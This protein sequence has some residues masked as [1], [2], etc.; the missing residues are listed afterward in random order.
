MTPSFARALM[1]GTFMY[2]A[3]VTWYWMFF[4]SI[5]PLGIGSDGSGSARPTQ[6]ESL[7]SAAI[8]DKCY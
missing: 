7:P 2:A 8:Q 6:P 4:E 3:R 1:D 5:W